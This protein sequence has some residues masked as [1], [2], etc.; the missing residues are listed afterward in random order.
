MK[1]EE[2][3]NREKLM[4]N[5]SWLYEKINKMNKPPARLA[6]KKRINKLQISGI[7]EK[8]SLKIQ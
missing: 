6:K 3:N 5:Q 1:H 8:L 4:K 2:K 7:K